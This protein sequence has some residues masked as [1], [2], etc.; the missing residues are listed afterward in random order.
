V[1]VED[2]IAKDAAKLD[3]ACRVEA[4]EASK[5]EAAKRKLREGY[6]EAEDAKR[7]RKIQLIEA[8][9]MLEQRKR[10]MQPILRERS[11]AR[12]GMPT[13]FRRCSV[14]SV[15]PFNRVKALSL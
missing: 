12:W 13:A 2:D 4:A 14:T 1:A 3:A 5:M 15:S 10:K 9:E 6:R 8:P 11:K 7:Q